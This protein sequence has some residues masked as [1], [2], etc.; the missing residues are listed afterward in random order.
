MPE[1]GSQC[2]VTANRMMPL[3][4]IQKSGALAPSSEST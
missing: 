1:V 2:S 4:A 3:I